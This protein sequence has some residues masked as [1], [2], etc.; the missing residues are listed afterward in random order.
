MHI[1][2]TGLVMTLSIGNNLNC[3][4]LNLFNNEGSPGLAQ[5]F[6]GDLKSLM[7]LAHSGSVRTRLMFNNIHFKH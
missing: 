6:P 3:V 1:P 2:L 4:N 7:L 5:T